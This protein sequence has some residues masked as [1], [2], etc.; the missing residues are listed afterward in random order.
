MTVWAK[1]NWVGLI[2]LPPLTMVVAGLAGRA[3]FIAV[4]GD[5]NAPLASWSF[6]SQLGFLT[7]HLVGWYLA[8]R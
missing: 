2:A 1:L 3:M 7:I 6:W 4:K 5:V 8:S